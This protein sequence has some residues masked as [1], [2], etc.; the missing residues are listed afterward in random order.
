M[1]E[2]DKRCSVRAECTQSSLRLSYSGRSTL[3]CQQHPPI[4]S[5]GVCLGLPHQNGWSATSSDLCTLQLCY[6]RVMR[7]FNA[8]FVLLP[9]L[10]ESLK[11]QHLRA[12]CEPRR[13]KP[14]EHRP[15]AT[16]GRPIPEFSYTR[17]LGG[18]QVQ[19]PKVCGADVVLRLR[20]GPDSP[21][22]R[23]HCRE[24]MVLPYVY[25]ITRNFP[26]TVSQTIWNFGAMWCPA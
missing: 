6:Y 5:V 12:F 3:N 20:R 8:L 22:G 10:R 15:W 19:R 14:S 25:F 26:L 11:C 24:S 16:M 4:I 23:H 7:G 9:R 2:S 13:Y 17:G 21:N 1:S 18:I